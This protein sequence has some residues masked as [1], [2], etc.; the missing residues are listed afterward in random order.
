MPIPTGAWSENEPSEPL[1]VDDPPTTI[2]VA[3]GSG[4]EISSNEALN[5]VPLTVAIPL[6]PPDPPVPP[7]PPPVPPVPPVPL[8][9]SESPQPTRPKVKPILKNNQ[10][11]LRIYPP[12]SEI[13]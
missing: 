13:V 5:T 11:Y 10:A 2:T 4:V 7:L 1:V 3:P 12:M 8:L 6:P 9:L